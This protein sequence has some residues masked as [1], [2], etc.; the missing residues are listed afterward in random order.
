MASRRN[1][2]Y[3]PASPASDVTL[4]EQSIFRRSNLAHSLNFLVI[5]GT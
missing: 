5:S 3:A 1:S 2:G 4:G